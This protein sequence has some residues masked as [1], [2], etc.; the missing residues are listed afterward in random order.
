MKVR[1]NPIPLLFLLMSAMIS[2]PAHAIHLQDAYN[3]AE[4]GEGYDKRLILEPDEIYTG[5]LVVEPRTSCVIHGNGALIVL[6]PAGYI[7]APSQ[8]KLDIDGCVIT[9]GAVGLNYD[10]GSNSTVENC[11]LVENGMGIRCWGTTVVI[12]NC[13]IANNYQYGIACLDT[14]E[15]V[16]LYNNVWANAQLDYAAY[17]PG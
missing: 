11:T 9:G 5:Y 17:C 14:F 10:W 3:Q 1:A 15:P 6:D 2:F 7:S 13:I 8:A 12:K 4:S 16:I